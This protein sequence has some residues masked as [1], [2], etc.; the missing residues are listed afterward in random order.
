[1]SDAPSVSHCRPVATRARLSIRCR[2]AVLR[3]RRRIRLVEIPVAEAV[4]GKCL[5]PR[6]RGRAARLSLAANAKYRACFGG[7]MKCR[8]KLTMMFALFTI[9]IVVEKEEGPEC[10]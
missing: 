9:L 3:Q 5:L 8:T 4:E 7:R 1:M 10:H 2:T 6:L